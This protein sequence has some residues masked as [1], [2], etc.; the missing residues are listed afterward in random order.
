MNDSCMGKHPFFLGDHSVM[1]SSMKEKNA[2]IKVLPE[3][4]IYRCLACGVT[5]NMGRRKYCSVDCRQRLRYK[6]D[7]RMGLVQALNT[8]FATFYFSED[9]IMMD[10]LPY[11][12]SEIFSFFYPRSPGRK[13]AEDFGQMANLLGDIW[14]AEKRRTNKRHLAS[15]RVL[16]C[17]QRNT[18]D[19]VCVKP[20]MLTVFNV[21]KHYLMQ[22]K[23]D[24]TVLWSPELTQLI[25]SAY[26]QQA[27][28]HHPDLG[29]DAETFRK[30]HRAYEEMVQWSENPALIR[31]RG[32]PDKWFYDGEKSRW[33]QP[34]CA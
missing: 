22:L 14:W 17:A 3:K 19:T 16:D 6:L 25:K 31:R 21:K 28:V 20:S 15:E 24:K 12:T 34:I 29:G 27:K 4:K 26:R 9:M 23:I 10:L 7:A 11:G 5:E 33:I 13:P 30:L 18:S 1:M 32:F 2:I 8:R